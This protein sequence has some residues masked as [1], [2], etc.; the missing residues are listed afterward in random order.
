M[1]VAIVMLNLFQHLSCY[2]DS[3][4]NPMAIGSG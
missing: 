4:M 3:E 1:D 2:Q